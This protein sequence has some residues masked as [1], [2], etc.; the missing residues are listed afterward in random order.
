MKMSLGLMSMVLL[1]ALPSTA[2]TKPIPQEQAGPLVA[3]RDRG[4][5][6]EMGSW[7]MTFTSK[8]RASERSLVYAVARDSASGLPTG[9]RMHKPI[10]ITKQLDKASPLL[11]A[12][13]TN[14]EVLTSMELTLD[15]S[16]KDA[17]KIGGGAG[18]VSLRDLHVMNVRRLSPTREEVTLEYGSIQVTN[19]HGGLMDADIWA[20]NR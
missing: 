12:A 4:G 15:G 11:M 17:A 19:L 18:K 5:A 14:H 2:Q 16:S 8:G 7:S 13:M 3:G 1:S 20:P 6:I 9:K 10:V